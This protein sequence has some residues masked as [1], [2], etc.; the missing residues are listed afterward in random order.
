MADLA[1][2]EE[3]LVAEDPV[4]AGEVEYFNLGVVLFNQEEYFLSH[5]CFEKIWVGKRDDDMFKLGYQG[6]IQ[7]SVGCYHLKQ[8]NR[9]NSLAQF[10]KALPKLE[11]YLPL[12]FNLDIFTLYVD[13]TDLIGCLKSNSVDIAMCI[14]PKLKLKIIK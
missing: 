4:E 10:N 14:L 9:I 13:I 1:E 8:K 11:K 7:V 5:E 12:F 6:L 3:V 2:E